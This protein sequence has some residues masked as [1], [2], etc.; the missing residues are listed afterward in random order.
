MGVGETEVLYHIESEVTKIDDVALFLVLENDI[1]SLW[2][3]WR[4]TL[5]WV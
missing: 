4:R 2:I 1:N 3:P 5:K